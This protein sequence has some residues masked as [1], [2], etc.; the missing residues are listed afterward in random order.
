[1]DLIIS[2]TGNLMALAA[3]D[4]VYATAVKHNKGTRVVH[5]HPSIVG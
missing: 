5:G 4:D 1:M 3:L 2:H